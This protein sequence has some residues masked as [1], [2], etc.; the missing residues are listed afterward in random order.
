MRL[1][2]LAVVV[3]ALIIGTLVIGGWLVHRWARRSTVT[4]P[5]VSRRWLAEHVNDKSGDRS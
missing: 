4:E 3:W 5:S 2:V 1:V